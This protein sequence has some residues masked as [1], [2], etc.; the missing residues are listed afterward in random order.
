M[1][2]HCSSF[3]LLCVEHII[4]WKI[5]GFP[6]TTVLDGVKQTLLFKVLTLV[7]AREPVLALS[8]YCFYFS[9]CIGNICIKVL[10]L[11]NCF[12]SDYRGFSF[13]P[14]CHSHIHNHSKHLLLL[15]PCLVLSHMLYG[16]VLLK[17][18]SMTLTEKDEQ[19]H[20]AETWHPR[21][22]LAGDTEDNKVPGVDSE[23]A[24]AH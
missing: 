15:K 24:T 2:L 7:S 12:F 21:M 9:A 17:H 23:N 4:F 20:C 3:L 5:C 6:D 11:F 1:L 18:L 14:L 22:H 10:L 16:H 13:Q 8:C 19:Q